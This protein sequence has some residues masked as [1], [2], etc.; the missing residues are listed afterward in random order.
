MAL[1]QVD[2]IS[3]SF[4]G[5]Q[6]LNNVSLNVESGCIYGL[7][8]PNGAGK[9]TLFNCLSRIYTPDQGRIRFDEVNLLKYAPHQIIQLGIARTFQNTE[10]FK[11]MNVLEHLI[12]GQHRISK[13]NL[14]SSSFGFGRKENQEIE[15]RA[16]K[17]IDLL[18]L[19]E[20]R[21]E[22]VR[23]LP[24]GYQK[25]VELGR[26]LCSMPKLLLLDEPAAGMNSTETNKLRDLVRRIRQEMRL[27]VMLVEH[28]MSFV[29]ELCEKILVLD[30]GQT[31]AEGLPNEIQI[32]EKVIEAYLGEGVDFAFT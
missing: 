32:N 12:V 18:G 10:L 8:G 28:D 19:T 17:I 25:L 7:I 14:I 22:G 9:S 4:G 16:E 30:F 26:A 29:M 20:I 5:V 31:I 2:G 15:S 6:A 23:D 11:S 3:V 13:G 1:L 24:L 21:H 27:T